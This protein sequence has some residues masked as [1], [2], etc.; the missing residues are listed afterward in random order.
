[1]GLAVSIFSRSSLGVSIFSKARKS[2]S[3]DGFVCLSVLIND[4]F[5]LLDTVF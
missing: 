5:S 3:S 1:M 2:E 4:V